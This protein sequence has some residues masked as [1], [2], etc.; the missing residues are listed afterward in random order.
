LDSNPA[1]SA[2]PRI[3]ISVTRISAT[4]ISAGTSPSCLKTFKVDTCLIAVP[5]FQSRRTGAESSAKGL[6][7]CLPS[8]ATTLRGFSLIRRGQS[9][10][11]SPA[12][13]STR[14][15]KR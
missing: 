9:S 15:A 4:L 13:V 14:V 8:A 2:F 5:T 1:V 7:F 11:G 10:T 3:R 6:R 12:T